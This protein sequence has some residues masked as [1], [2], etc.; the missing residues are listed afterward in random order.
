MRKIELC[1]FDERRHA[2]LLRDWLTRPHV[3]RW[4]GNPQRSIDH[5]MQCRPDAHAVVA[6]DGSAVGYLCWQVPPPDELAEAGLE[7]LP[8]QLVDIDIFIGEPGLL[9]LGIG[10]R[11]LELLLARLRQESSFAYAGV[12]PSLSNPRAIR[13]YEKAGFRPFRE[14]DDA[15]WGRCR[16]MVRALRSLRSRQAAG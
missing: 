9:G 6:S 3:V 14:F 8:E 16:Y 1:A 13:A 15:E 2:A 11:A 12:G 5:V 4:W 10:T 7:D